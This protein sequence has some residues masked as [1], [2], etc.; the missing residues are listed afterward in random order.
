[1]GDEKQLACP[2]EGPWSQRVVLLTLTD[3]LQNIPRKGL[4]PEPTLPWAIELANGRRC[5]LFTGATAPVAGRRI[6]YGCPGGFQVVGDIDR[7]SALLRVFFQAENASALEQ[8]DVA[9][10]WY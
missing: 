8:V 6:N 1:M 5:S 9:V 7:S 4:P 2:V 10:A 3:A